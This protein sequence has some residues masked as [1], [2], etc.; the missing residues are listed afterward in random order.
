M[1]DKPGRSKDV[2]FAVAL[3]ATALAAFFVFRPFL[4]GG[5]GVSPYASEIAAALLGSVLTGAI[6][7]LLLRKQTETQSELQSKQDAFQARTERSKFI[8]EQ[9]VEV[10]QK[11][12]DAVQ[13]LMTR[14]AK[15]EAGASKNIPVT[16]A[17][18]ASM[19]IL[20]QKLAFLADKAVL[21]SFS[22]FVGQFAALG[23]DDKLTPPELS[24]LLEKVGELSVRVRF[25]LASAEERKEFDEEKVRSLV[26]GNIAQLRG[27]TN[28]KSFL[29][30]CDDAEK[31]YFGPLFKFFESV[32]LEPRMGTTGFSVQG[33]DGKSILNCFP[34]SSRR[35]IE[36]LIANV[37]PEKRDQALD[38]LKRKGRGIETAGADAKSVSFRTSVLDEVDLEQVIQAMR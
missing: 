23:R 28:E 30:A 32:Q 37:S 8:L 15:S 31:G 35:N 29:D 19:Q 21:E 16:Q 22:Q 6:T 17:D 9:K 1:G 24:A 7:L 34:T 27:Q 36:V 11:L 25:D 12:M 26:Q 33:Q 38:I 13:S 14:E 5:A 18:F 4:V 20:N 10:Y 3:V 2:W